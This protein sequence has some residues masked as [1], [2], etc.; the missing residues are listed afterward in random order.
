[1][2]LVYVT[3]A[4]DAPQHA[5]LG[6][7]LT[8][9]WPPEQEGCA[10]GALVRVQIAKRELLG[11]VTEVL[12]ERPAS[13]PAGVA[14][15]PVAQMLA[16]LPPLSHHWLA[17]TRFAARYYQRSHGELALAALPP[18]LRELTAIQLARRSARKPKGEVSAPEPQAPPE[19][20]AEQ[21]AALEAL[22]QEAA[23]PKAR[24]VLLWGATGSGKTEVYLRATAKAL[25]AKPQAQVLIL[26]PEINLTPQLEERVAERFAP[27]GVSVVALHSGLPPAQRLKNWLAAH[28]GAARIVLGTRIGVLASMPH[29]ALIVVDEEHD[30]SYKAQ[31]GARYSARDLAVWRGKNEGIP[32]LLGSATPSLESWHASE[33]TASGEER[34]GRYLR[35]HMPS[36]IGSGALP[37]LRLLN[38]AQEPKGGKNTVLAPRLVAALKERIARGEQSLLLLNRR[39]YAPV[40]RCADCEWKSDCPNCSA[41]RVFHKIDRSL[42]CHHCGLAEAVP[43][44][45][46]SCGSLDLS[47]VGKGTERLE[48]TVAELLAGLAK[49]SGEPLQ[50]ARIDT[51]S[52]KRVGQLAEQLAAVH[53]G[54]VDVLIG[55]QMLAKGHDFRRITLVAA[56]GVDAALFSSD[57]RA[58]ERLFALLMQVGGR[59]GRDAQLAAAAELW[60]QTAAS[61]HP[62]FA[63][64]ATHDFARFAHAQL[65]DRRGALLPPFAHQALLRADARSQEAAQAYLQAA[66]NLGADLAAELAVTLY[67]PVPLSIQRVAGVERAQMLVEAASRAALQRFLAAWQEPLHGLAQGAHARGP[68]RIIR[69]AIDVDPLHI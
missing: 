43:R 29:L 28:T 16:G 15:K 40:L 65:A 13:V 21:S 23:Q 48:E 31:D 10:A 4:V 53:R 22:T 17:L 32:V 37:K 56:L 24:P 62:L 41:Y 60:V 47:V 54:D 20:S 6:L 63:P 46:P 57:Y 64:L 35:L 51:D 19:L 30:P 25:A 38:L 44:A 14:I 1:M 5:G 7:G 12:A 52:T 67:P 18:Q 59:A 26:V 58:Q 50:V 39:G 61:D 3:V 2:S 33:P 45:C 49:P 34:A 27:Q 8:Y 55:T 66:Q 11:V 9:T 42:R 69:W 36:R 68:E